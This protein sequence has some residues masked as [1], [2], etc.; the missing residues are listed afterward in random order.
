MFE[1][2]SRKNMLSFMF[3]TYIFLGNQNDGEGDGGNFI[4]I[5]S[6]VVMKLAEHKKF[7]KE[8]IRAEGAA[9]T[10]FL[11]NCKSRVIYGQFT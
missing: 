2:R 7:T 3:V 8:K 1:E 4:F 5:I 6:P 11:H 9:M 10:A